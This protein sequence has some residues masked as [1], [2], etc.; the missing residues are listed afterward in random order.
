M[1]KNEYPGKLSCIPVDEHH[2]PTDMA[3]KPELNTLRGSPLPSLDEE[4]SAKGMKATHAN[5][6]K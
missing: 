6:G 1:P 5:Y 4:P 2:L 3:K